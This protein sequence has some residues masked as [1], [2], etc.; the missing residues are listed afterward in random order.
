MDANDVLDPCRILHI[1]DGGHHGK[2]G[3]GGGELLLDGVEGELVQLEQH[4][5]LRAEAR[6]LAREL[7]ADRTAGAGDHHHP[8]G[9]PAAK[10]RGVERHRVAP[11]QVIEL[12]VAH[13]RDGD[14]PAHEIVG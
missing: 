11:E 14:A 6:D 8:A 1:A 10:S 3:V 12:D 5:L 9:E 2:P 7:G 13:L 4:Q